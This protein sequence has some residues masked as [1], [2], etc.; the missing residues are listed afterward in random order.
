MI[1]CM[2]NAAEYPPH[3][4]TQT[5]ILKFRNV[6]HWRQ[7]NYTNMSVWSDHRDLEPSQ[8]HQQKSGFGIHRKKN[9]HKNSTTSSGNMQLSSICTEKDKGIHLKDDEC[10]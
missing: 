5:H 10:Q 8:I 6:R 3:T 4:Y 9:K 7:Y 1:F 2:I